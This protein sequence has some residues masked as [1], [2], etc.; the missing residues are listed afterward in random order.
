MENC[1]TGNCSRDIPATAGY[2]QDVNLK[3]P[4]FEQTT[5]STLNGLYPFN[6]SGRCPSCGYC[7]HCGRSD[8]LKPYYP[9]NPYW[10]TSTK[11]PENTVYCEAKPQMSLGARTDDGSS[12]LQELEKAANEKFNC[13]FR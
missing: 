5:S 1:L 13:Q 2:C 7:P 8:G 3:T 6:I 12:I 11:S 4:E 9:Q 10:M